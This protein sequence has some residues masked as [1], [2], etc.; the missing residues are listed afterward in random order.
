[1]HDTPARLLFEDMW[2][3]LVYTRI[4]QIFKNFAHSISNITGQTIVVDIF[5]GV[6]INDNFSIF[7]DY[8][9]KDNSLKLFFEITLDEK[10]KIS[11]FIFD[12]NIPVEFRGHG[13]GS[14][15]ICELLGISSRLKF[16][17][18]ILNPANKRA[19]NFWAKFGFNAQSGTRLMTLDPVRRELTSQCLL[20]LIS[21]FRK[22]TGTGYIQAA[23]SC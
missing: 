21:A 10:Q 20:L 14:R 7:C 17:R 12:F 4:R 5:E 15:I 19:A 18:V 22:N 6:G 23:Q 16:S 13:I 2:K 1:M 8:I 3:K 9:S 11:L